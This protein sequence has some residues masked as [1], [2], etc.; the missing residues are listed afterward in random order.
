MK[1]NWV[2]VWDY[3][4]CNEITFIYDDDPEHIAVLYTAK[5]SMMRSALLTNIIIR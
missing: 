3:G 4:L 5:T 1:E 2:L